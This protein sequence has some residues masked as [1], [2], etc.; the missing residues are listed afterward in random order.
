MSSRV[1]HKKDK[2]PYMVTNS[3]SSESCMTLDNIPTQRAPVLS[4][5]PLFP[6]DVPV[7]DIFLRPETDK[8]LVKINPRNGIVLPMEKHPKKI[9][10]LKWKFRSHESGL[11]HEETND[12]NLLLQRISVSDWETHVKTRFSE[13]ENS[14][15]EHEDTLD[16]EELN[17]LKILSEKIH[18]FS[19]KYVKE[20]IHQLDKFIWDFNTQEKSNEGIQKELDAIYNQELKFCDEHKLLFPWSN[21]QRFSKEHQVAHALIR[22]LC[23]LHPENIRKLI[24]HF[25]F[26]SNFANVPLEKIEDF[27]KSKEEFLKQLVKHEAEHFTIFMNDWDIRFQNYII[28]HPIIL[29]N[30]CIG[31]VYLNTTCCLIPFA[32]EW[33]SQTAFYEQKEGPFYQFLHANEKVSILKDG[34]IQ[35]ISLISNSKN[36]LTELCNLD[37]TDLHFLSVRQWDQSFHE[38]K[39]KEYSFDE[40]KDSEK[41]ERFQNDVLKQIEK[42]KQ[43]LSCEFWKT[44]LLKTHSALDTTRSLYVEIDPEYTNI[45]EPSFIWLHT[46]FVNEIIT[47]TEGR[48]PFLGLDLVITQ[49]PDT[50]RSLKMSTTRMGLLNNLVLQNNLQ[51]AEFLTN[52]INNSD[53]TQNKNIQ[54][55]QNLNSIINLDT[56]GFFNLDL[57]NEDDKWI[58][59]QIVQSIMYKISRPRA[60]HIIR[61]NIRRFGKYGLDFMYQMLKYVSNFMNE[62]FFY[63]D[64]LLQDTK[65]YKINNEFNFKKVLCTGNYTRYFYL[66]CIS[67]EWC[68]IN[69]QYILRMFAKLMVL[70][71]SKSVLAEEYKIHILFR[72]F[73]SFV[74]D[75]LD[76]IYS[77]SEITQ[78]IDFSKIEIMEEFKTIY[79]K[80]N[81]SAVDFR[82]E[83]AYLKK[84]QKYF[85]IN[86]KDLPN[87]QKDVWKEIKKYQF[88]NSLTITQEYMNINEILD[89][90]EITLEDKDRELWK[91]TF[92]D[93]FRILK[94][95]LKKSDESERLKIMS[96]ITQQHLKEENLKLAL[97]E[98]D[99][100]KWK[101]HEKLRK[102]EDIRRKKEEEEE[103]IRIEQEE[104]EYGD[105][106][107]LRVLRKKKLDKTKDVA[108]NAI[109]QK[110]MNTP[111]DTS[112]K[113]L[114]KGESGKQLQ[115]R[116]DNN[117]KLYSME[118]IKRIFNQE[119]GYDYELP[120]FFKIQNKF[121]NMEQQRHLIR[122]ILEN[123]RLYAKEEKKQT[124]GWNEEAE[125]MWT[126]DEDLFQHNIQSK[127][128]QA[129]LMH[130]LLGSKSKHDDQIKSIEDLTK[131][132]LKTYLK[133]NPLWVD[134][135]T[136][137]I[138][139]ALIQ[140]TIF[141]ASI[142]DEAKQFTQITERQLTSVLNSFKIRHLFV[143]TENNPEIYEKLF[144]KVQNPNL[145]G[146]DIAS[147]L[148]NTDNSDKVLN[149]WRQIFENKKS[150]R[151]KFNMD[152][153]VDIFL[154]SR[155]SAKAERARTEALSYLNQLENNAEPVSLP[156]TDDG[157]KY[158][159][160]EALLNFPKRDE[161]E[162]LALYNDFTVEKFKKQLKKLHYLDPAKPDEIPE[163]LGEMFW[164]LVDDQR[165]RVEERRKLVMLGEQLSLK[166]NMSLKKSNKPENQDSNKNSPELPKSSKDT[167]TKKQ[168][169]KIDSSSNV[170][171]IENLILFKPLILQ[172]FPFRCPF[173][174][175]TGFQTHQECVNHL[176]LKIGDKSH[177]E[178]YSKIKKYFDLTE[179]ANQRCGENTFWNVSDHCELVTHQ[180]RAK[181]SVV[182][183]EDY[184]EVQHANHFVLKYR[185]IP[186]DDDHEGPIITPNDPFYN[187]KFEF[188]DYFENAMNYIFGFKQGPAYKSATF[189]HDKFENMSEKYKIQLFETAA[190]SA[191]RIAKR[192]YDVY[193][194]GVATLVRKANRSKN[195]V[196]AERNNDRG[197]RSR[198]N[199]G[200]WRGDLNDEAEG[201]RIADKDKLDFDEHNEGYRRNGIRVNG[202]WH[203]FS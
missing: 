139:S 158:A 81:K 129:I 134:D 42:K 102:E 79:S 52:M 179:K 96:R 191:S 59:V 28:T 4:Q 103:N 67:C 43:S 190:Q 1:I 112:E 2:N 194:P 119:V 54:I 40:Y 146:N 15:K 89:V 144:N 110:F 186:L 80:K 118:E 197:E 95:V 63:L 151:N 76:D 181:N 41:I 70:Y 84:E 188:Y 172:H 148:E 18:S 97:I 160:F 44:I 170:N 47:I 101:L 167:S 21:S 51:S 74:A 196:R 61:S 22:S 66:I 178:L 189:D 132:I 161:P 99:K 138:S 10:P 115:Q 150:F 176:E 169:V 120:D 163:A 38:F 155:H 114:A 36:T 174:K 19:E 143:A 153:A 201:Q 127:A 107:D 69:I 73:S 156:E 71:N 168:N 32:N 29:R 202:R 60:V 9:T 109:K 175:N 104:R 100:R 7:K 45:D 142:I 162:G 24:Q 86:V 117:M 199:N 14:I 184:Q 37:D 13:I 136:K 72:E 35:S 198:D 98:D 12:K 55:F 200:N 152:K 154:N 180:I 23:H 77:T 85:W 116:A 34:K 11:T 157:F 3:S 183:H 166:I 87:D 49:N 75:K 159:K 94:D 27:W 64:Q 131:S 17:N 195:K 39:N 203:S 126:Y 106:N 124:Y 121:M 68:I 177:S 91:T 171:P 16:V 50:N 133:I 93:P 128:D 164:F 182:D 5:E 135:P 123:Q 26:Q 58:Y 193:E 173:C 147:W 113:V 33:R 20:Q 122:E 141:L 185:Y 82:K 105:L 111:Q 31:L 46:F 192:G 62:S 48:M 25:V 57:K 187:Y 90:W 130:K 56:S 108:R 83:S 53:E 30:I 145:Y 92:K 149:F 125:T 140:K 8:F 78:E 165:K 65:F 88:N 137:K 6:Q